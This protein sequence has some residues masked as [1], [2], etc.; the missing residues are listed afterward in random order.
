MSACGGI[1]GPAG[2]REGR[3]FSPAETEAGSTGL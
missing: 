3:G 2:K 1:I